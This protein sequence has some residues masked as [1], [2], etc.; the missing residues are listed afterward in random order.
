[1][2]GFEFIV[3]ARLAD[4]QTLSICLCLS[5]SAEVIGVYMGPMM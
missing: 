4:Q 1:M 2:V 5:S 3:L